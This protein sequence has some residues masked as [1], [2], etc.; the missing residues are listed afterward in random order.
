[1]ETFEYNNKQAEVKRSH[2]FP[3]H[4][5]KN[6]KDPF[7]QPK[8]SIGPTDDAYER[9]AD[10]VA[11]KVMRMDKDEVQTKSSPVQI[12]KK[13]A[14]CEEETQRVQR[15]SSEGK[16]HVPSEVNDAL[17]AP[18][19]SL[20]NSTTSFMES[21][22]GYNF[23]N[24]KIHTDALAAK[25]AQSINALAYTSKNSI[26][27]NEGQYAPG[28]EKGNRLLAHEL[29][30]V[31]QQGG[32]EERINRKGDGE[33]TEKA[34][35]LKDKKDKK[36]D[37]NADPCTFSK[38]G[39]KDREIHLN[40]SKNA[41]KVFKNSGSGKH[42]ETE[43]TGLITGPSTVSL[44]EKNGW[45]HMYTVDAKNPGPSPKKKLHNF[46]VYCGEFGFHS[47]HW[48]NNDKGEIKKIPGAES[49]GCARIPDGGD[50]AKGGS[51]KFFDL[52]EV[53]DCVRIYQ[54][55]F[56]REPTF[57]NCSDN[58]QCKV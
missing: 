41:V 31:I 21:R 36:K 48:T 23:G 37:E 55:G 17:N 4:P 19:Q 49:H 40:L 14:Q 35:E 20:D 6:R 33:E 52:V 10:A 45:C 27:F 42:T 58:D 29:T 18:G 34:E 24:V 7:F 26:V 54:R 51:K 30:H 53:G 57:A 50:F 8:L 28:T 5:G 44:A 22:F 15:K 9:E 39:T 47:D 56:W 46:V 1:M 11:D 43:F 16:S 13:C 25:S 32:S 2:S 3:A 12:Q 38:P